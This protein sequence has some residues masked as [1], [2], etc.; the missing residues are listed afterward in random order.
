MRVKSSADSSDHHKRQ[1]QHDYFACPLRTSM[2]ELS[3]GRQFG[4][5][6]SFRHS[7]LNIPDK[8]AKYV[9]RNPYP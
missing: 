1:E 4:L 6:F 9:L 3:L 7:L 2:G 8:I 5:S